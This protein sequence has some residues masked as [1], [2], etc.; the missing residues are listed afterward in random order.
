MDRSLPPDS[1]PRAA[2]SAPATGGT[3]HRECRR[4][5]ARRAKDVGSEPH[6]H[7]SGCD[8]GAEL[9]R[10][11]P[12]LGTDDEDHVTGGR[13]LE[14]GQGALGILVQD[15]GQCGLADPLY[16]GLLVRRH[17][18]HRHAGPP[19]LLGRGQHDRLPLAQRPGRSFP[20]PDHDA[21]SRLPRNDLI[22]PELGGGLD[23]LLVPITLG[24]GLNQHK[25]RIRLRFK[26][27]RLHSQM[28][29]TRTD[30]L[31]DGLGAMTAP[32]GEQHL[33]TDA[34]PL[35]GGGMT[36]LRTV[37]DEHRPGSGPRQPIRRYEEQRGGHV[38]SFGAREDMG[39]LAQERVAQLAEQ[40]LRSGGETT[41][42]TLLAS[43][44]RKLAQHVLLRGGELGRSLDGGMDQEVAASGPA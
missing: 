13:K 23:G 37:Q 36:T 41:L 42:R 40:S 5:G 4:S 29:L 34:D 16:D 38:A 33:L 2:G 6:H 17:T 20:A 18:H 25:A 26:R 11:D 30:A 8:E 28:Q 22:H 44:H 14:P 32:V 15:E 21:A 10:R 7:R 3:H 1:G 12:A 9:I 43:Q 27:Y 35:D 24:Q 39:L 31:D 19:R